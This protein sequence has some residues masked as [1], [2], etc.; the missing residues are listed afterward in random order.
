M[1]IIFGVIG[2]TLVAELNGEIDHHA[3]KGIREKIDEA[4]DNY[5]ANALVFDFSEV[6][7]MDSSGIGMILGRYRKMGEK[8][9]K[10]AISSC[11]KPIR[12][13]L[14]MAGV[15]SIID[16]YDTKEEAVSNLGRKEVS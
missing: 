4:L 16:Y 3:V 9:N 14:N 8:E 10:I 6:T 11:S 7:F 2:N 15:F 5:S 12:N 13:I 1:E